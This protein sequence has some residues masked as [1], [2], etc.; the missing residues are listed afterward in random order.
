MALRKRSSLRF[1]GGLGLL[2]AAIWAI[3]APAVSAQQ[4]VNVL[5]AGS[6]V[7]LMEH[8]IGP[9][10]DRETGDRFQGYAGGSN[11]LANQIKGKLRQADVFIS[12]NPKVNAGL[13]G[14]SNG[15]WVS[16]YISFAQ[17]P[18]VIGYSPSSRFAADFKSRSWYRVLMEPGIRIGRTDPKLDPKGALALQLMGQAE[19]L[20]GIPGLSRRVLGELE[21]PAQV[22]PEEA[23]IGRLQSGLLDAGFFYS[24]ETADARIPE[25]ELPASIGPKAV[26][27]VTI[28]RDAPHPGGADRFVAFLLGPAGQ[29]QLKDHGLALQKPALTGAARIV[30]RDLQ[31]ILD[32]AY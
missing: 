29:Q 25:V 17:S 4:T 6:L 14:P 19:T 21:N 18:L 27:T 8:G 11:A 22:L 30:P 20:Y 1:V 13:T 28:L 5:Y 32:P 31:S 12:A 2:A 26:Y 15:S 24:T 23:L 7:N 10:F 16:W 3:R 9:A